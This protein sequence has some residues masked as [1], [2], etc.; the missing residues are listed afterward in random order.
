MK[1]TRMAGGHEPAA[2]ARGVQHVELALVQ[3]QRSVGRPGVQHRHLQPRTSA[4]WNGGNVTAATADPAGGP[5]RVLDIA[6]AL[7]LRASRSAA[8][9]S[10]APFVF[11]V[12]WAL[13]L[14]LLSRIAASF[15]CW[16]RPTLSAQDLAPA[17]A[18][19][20]SE[21]VAALKAGQLDRRRRRFATCWPRAGTR[22]RPSQ[23]RYRPAAAESSRRGARGVSRGRPA[24]S[25]VRART[26]ARRHEPAGPRAGREAVAELDRAVRLLPGEK[27]AH[28]QLAHAC[29]LAGNVPCLARES[30]VAGRAS[31]RRTPST[32][33][34]S[35][36]RTSGS[37]SGR[38]NGS[39]R[40]IRGLPA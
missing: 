40:S 1:N 14:G 3:R 36:R 9:L 6:L 27:A 17:L 25:V 29:E 26:T 33:T 10:A 24:R 18:A 39:A 37:R 11:L 34:A 31:R 38:S 12:P 28:L 8:G 13:P 15:C 32:P 20:F 22:I 35:A 2:P 7:R 4:Q 21:G 23:P 19:R 30:R 16:S 5:V